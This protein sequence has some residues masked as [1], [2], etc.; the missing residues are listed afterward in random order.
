MSQETPV[1]G[2]EETT[3]APVQETENPLAEIQR[4][5]KALRI[6]QNKIQQELDSERSKWV[7][8]LKS[9]PGQKLKEYG[10]STDQLA[11][12]FLGIEEERDPVKEKLSEFD[13]YLSSQKKKEE[14]QLISDY[15]KKVFSTV[16]KD[17]DK[18]ELI[19]EHR[20]G[21]NLFL[22]KV[23]EHFNEYGEN[24]SES[25]MAEIADKVETQLFDEA[26]KLLKLKKFA[27][28]DAPKSEPEAKTEDAVKPKKTIS[29][30]LTASSAPT[31]RIVA[32]DAAGTLQTT[33]KF[34]AYMDE[35]EAKWSQIAAAIQA[36]QTQG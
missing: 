20:D 10:I 11:D 24:P 5:E 2:V 8:E 27:P 35:K 7:N 28:K 31:A 21:K 1:A 33:S 15:Q 19:N 18:F 23:L 14:Q 9:N 13:A 26:Q 30:S 36:K 17:R 29:S 25:E 32:Q 4:R 3:A 6:K 12:Q 22:N 16:E 34:K